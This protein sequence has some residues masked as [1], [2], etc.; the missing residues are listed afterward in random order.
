MVRVMI[1]KHTV[2][3]FEN[4]NEMD[5]PYLLFLA[6]NFDRLICYKKDVEFQILATLQLFNLRWWKPLLSLNIMKASAPQMTGLTELTHFLAPLDKI[7][8]TNQLLPKIRHRGTWLLGPKEALSNIT[9]QEF[10]YAD[11]AFIDFINNKNFQSLDRLIAILYRPKKA[12]F[13]ENSPNY[14]GDLRIAFNAFKINQQLKRIKYLDWHY[15]MA[16]CMFFWGSRNFLAKAY[17]HVFSSG[18]KR[19]AKSQKLGWIQVIF[20]LSGEKF[21]TIQQTA[22]EKLYT[23]LAFLEKE[24]INFSKNKKS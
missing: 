24:L 12:C 22:N 6:K 21:G 7:D 19:T 13:S 5:K 10:A 23:V 3:V 11:K 8:L 9:L 17:P 2:E 18:N 14:Q 15:K 16:I 4:W 20:D 1:G